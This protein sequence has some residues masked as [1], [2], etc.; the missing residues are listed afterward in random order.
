M[1]RTAAAPRI[2]VGAEVLPW[3]PAVGAYV[4]VEQGQAAAAELVEVPGVGGIWTVLTTPADAKFSSAEPGLRITFCFLD[5]DPVETAKRLGPTLEKRWAQ[6]DITPLL[7]A[8]FQIVDPATLGS[9][10]P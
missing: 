1:E 5:D 2:K 6:T 7:A 4:L 3:W 8:P 10:L 9:H